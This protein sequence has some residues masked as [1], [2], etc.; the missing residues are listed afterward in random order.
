M[1]LKCV[2]NFVSAFQLRRLI[3]THY[4]QQQRNWSCF[5]SKIKWN[6]H[7][8]NISKKVSTRLYFLRQLERAKV[9]SKIC[10]MNAHVKS[11]TKF[12]PAL[13][14]LHCKSDLKW[15]HNFFGRIFATLFFVE[16]SDFI[17]LANN[18]CDI[19][20]HNE[21]LWDCLFYSKLHLY[22]CKLWL[23]T[24]L[25]HLWILNEAFSNVTIQCDV[26]R[27]ML[28][29]LPNKVEYLDKV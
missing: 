27:C 25:P 6:S 9:P 15:Q 12:C 22:V 4:Y 7:I 23:I 16:I 11:D 10:C 28:F 17:R 13:S 1:Q 14:W 18:T 20:L 8:N 19:T 21:C 3:L 5:L 24:I 26:K 29:A 2:N